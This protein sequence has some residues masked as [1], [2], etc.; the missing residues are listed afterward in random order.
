MSLERKEDELELRLRI[1]FILVI[2]LSLSLSLPLSLLLDPD[3]RSCNT[4][5]DGGKWKCGL[6]KFDKIE[7]AYNGV[8][9]PITQMW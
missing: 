5:V 6:L 9:K 8:I 3:S 7:L 4:G 1:G 2:S